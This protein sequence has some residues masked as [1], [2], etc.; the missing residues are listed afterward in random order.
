MAKNLKLVTDNQ[1]L[2]GAPP[3]PLGQ[4]GM[5][6]WQSVIAQHQIEDAAGVEFTKKF[7]IKITRR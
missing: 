3:R 5:A 1:P 4:H 7:T 6:L 2:T